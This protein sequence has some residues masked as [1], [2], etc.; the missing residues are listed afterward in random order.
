MSLTCLVCLF[1]QNKV[2]FNVLCLSL[3]SALAGWFW[4]VL[5]VVLTGLFPAD[6][7]VRGK[8]LL[9][10]SFVSG[11]KM[12]HDQT[13]LKE[14]IRILMANILPQCIAGNVG[15]HRSSNCCQRLRLCATKKKEDCLRSKWPP[16]DRSS[17]PV[18][19]FIFAKKNQHKLHQGERKQCLLQKWSW[20]SSWCLMF[21]EM[22]DLVFS[23][24]SAPCFKATACTDCLQLEE[25]LNLL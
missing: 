1:K 14:G 2:F 8:I 12:L 6:N 4:P 20:Q 19:D 13:D 18:C 21:W 16:T 3:V 15:V 7:L 9:G 23:Q 25:L 22:I 24:D 11:H 5:F 10:F 17:Q